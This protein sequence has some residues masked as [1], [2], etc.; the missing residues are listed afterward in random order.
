MKCHTQ[1]P[2]HG[3]DPQ[4][5]ASLSDTCFLKTGGE[6]FQVISRVL[7][8]P[9]LP[10]RSW[11]NAL[12]SQVYLEFF[13]TGS[14]P[15]HYLKVPQGCDNKEPQTRWLA[16]IEM[17]SQGPGSRKSKVK[18]STGWLLLEALGRSG[19]HASALASG[20]CQCNPW[21]SLACGIINTVPASLVSWP[22]PTCVSL[23]MRT[24]VIGFRAH[25]N[26]MWSHLNFILHLQRPFSRRN[27][28]S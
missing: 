4:R 24:P 14:L 3:P 28:H 10:G 26:L 11:W 23:L 21:Y 8:G 17:Y 15:W 16:A 19:F 20:S 27:S 13:S 1:K 18:L 25:T 6:G 7:A 2:F 5:L 22:S 12:S 9:E